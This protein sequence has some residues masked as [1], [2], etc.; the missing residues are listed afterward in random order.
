M[1]TLIKIKLTNQK[2]QINNFISLGNRGLLHQHHCCGAWKTSRE[3]KINMAEKL[4]DV[5]VKLRQR[6]KK[7]QPLKLL[8]DIKNGLTTSL[9][10]F[11]FFFWKMA[12]ILVGRRSKESGLIQFLLQ[13]TVY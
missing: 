12:K 3:P 11:F 8:C 5:I 2:A 6:W 4:V 9:L 13:H 10:F 7:D 1:I